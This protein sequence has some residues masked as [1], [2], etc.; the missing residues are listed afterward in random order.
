MGL[1]FTDI[2]DREGAALYLLHT[3]NSVELDRLTRL[4]Q[5]IEA[6]DSHQVVLIDVNT[7]DGE[8]VRDFY[9][10]EAGSLPVALIIG[11]DDSIVFRWDNTA[12][13][14][15]AGDVVYQLGRASA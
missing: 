12:I 9:D 2:P 10:I 14:T 3:G 4:K 15:A 8:K 5:D 1:D 13:P 11:D 7:P 6:H